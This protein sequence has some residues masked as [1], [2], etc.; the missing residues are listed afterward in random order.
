MS[1]ISIKENLRTL[2]ARFGNISVSDL[3]K[4]TGIPQPTLHLL[5]AGT[6]EH[7]RKKTLETLSSFFSVTTNQLLGQEPLPDTLPKQMLEQLDFFPT[8]IITW[9][10]LTHFP[11]FY[12]GDHES[13]FLESNAS[14]S[15]FALKM[16]GSSME[17]VFPDG[18]L[19]I[20][21]YNKA[22]KDRDC[23]LVYIK[24][25]D[26]YLFKKILI[27]GNANYV[28]SINSELEDISTYIL[29][30]DDKIIATLI[31]ARLKF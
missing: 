12:S 25:I 19:L 23:V 3:A 1:K 29:F 31:E 5:Y 7:P 14:K 10:E 2:M 8:P 18:S 13:V 26:Q 9:E 6:T 28:K 11:D 4:S 17:P 30:H 22:P 20:F 21:D 24:K 15:T 16:K 27:D